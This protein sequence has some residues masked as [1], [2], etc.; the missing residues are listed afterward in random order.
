M[1]NQKI[2]LFQ[3]KKV[4]REWHNDQWHFS[5]VDVI[6]VLTDS[7]APSKYWNALK[8]REPQVSTICRKLKM[9]GADGKNYPTEVANTEGL[10]RIIMSVP[11]PKA[12]PFKLWLAQ[13]GREHIEEIENPELGFERLRQIY[14]AKGYSD[15]WIALRGKSIEIRKELTDEWKKRGI[16][17]NKEYSILTS[18]IAKATFGLT[19]SEHSKL[20]NLEKQN[21]RDHMTNLELIFS[22]L[23]EESTRLIA[24]K[25]D[26]QGFE[27]NREA[28]IDGGSLAGK[29]RRELE[30]RTGQKVVSAENFL[31]L[32]PSDEVKILTQ[33][34][35]NTEG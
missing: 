26:A 25:D 20:K 3:E 30:E 5:V 22:A 27:Q 19:P 21:L 32:K 33:K 29:Y 9:K 1:E 15:D 11:S 16:S 8:R 34:N 13:V 12:E 23:G 6:E 17:E 2:I 35:E 7:T 28:A 4:R 10:L 24:E 18:E 31:N 14:K